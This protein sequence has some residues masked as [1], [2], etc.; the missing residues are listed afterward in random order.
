MEPIYFLTVKEEADFKF[1]ELILKAQLSHGCWQLLLTSPVEGKSLFCI[2]YVCSQLLSYCKINGITEPTYIA[3]NTNFGR[4]P[5]CRTRK[6]NLITSSADIKG[7]NTALIHSLSNLLDLKR[8]KLIS[9]IIHIMAAHIIT[10][11]GSNICVCNTD[12]S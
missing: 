2:G 7:F 12:N 4:M 6:L 1:P 5:G 9:N 8:A 10:R 11:K 3:D